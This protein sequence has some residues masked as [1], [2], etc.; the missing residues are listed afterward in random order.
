MKLPTPNLKP[1][2]NITR[3]SHV[4][5]GVKDLDA[6]RKFYVDVLGLVVTSEEGD[7]LY[8]RGLEEGCHHSLVLKESPHSCC[9]RIGMRVLL[10]ED[11]DPLKAYFEKHGLPTG[12]VDVA[13]QGKTLRAVDPV[14]TKLE[15]CASMETRP[16]LILNYKEFHG[17]SPMRLDH[18]QI[19]APDVVGA[20]DFYSGMGFR[21]SEYILTEGTNEPRM[22]FMHRKGNPHDIVFTG[23]PGPR[24][25]HI[26]LTCPE[27]YHLF[28]VCDVAASHGYG[29]SVEYGP[30]RHFGPGYALFVYIRDPDG[31]R[32]EFFNNHY[33]TI[34]IEDEPIKFT[35]SDV[36]GPMVWGI[37]RP[38][39]WRT[40]ASPFG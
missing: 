2:F 16:R 26:A 39:T 36:Y 4:V 15:F 3:A 12:W 23:A 27:S 38:E 1:G 5:L 6:S 20:M 35:E 22:I 7:T 11:L 37:E 21:L 29:G 33:Q 34:D 25:H 31:H 8:L 40:E 9:M 28:H 19:F 10:E 24:L 17:A 18:V 13:H 14:G 32:I 30:G